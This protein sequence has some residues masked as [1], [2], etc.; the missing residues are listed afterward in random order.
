MK[1]PIAHQQEPGV[2]RHLAPLV[3][4]EGDGIRKLDA[5]NQR[6]KLRRPHRQRTERA[7]DVKADLL[8]AAQFGNGA[9]IVDS[10]GVHRSRGRDHNE[11]FQSVRAVFANRLAQRRDVHAK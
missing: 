1:L 10:A 7:I 3:K 8:F 11:G 9:K 4:I 5:R 2:I 6:R